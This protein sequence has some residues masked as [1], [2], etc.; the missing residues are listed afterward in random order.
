MTEGNAGFIIIYLNSLLSTLFIQ[1]SK[2]MNQE[3]SKDQDFYLYELIIKWFR[4]YEFHSILTTS[5][6]IPNFDFLTK[7]E[8]STIERLILRF[9][10]NNLNYSL[11]IQDKFLFQSLYDKKILRHVDEKLGLE[12]EA[13]ASNEAIFNNPLISQ[14]YLQHA[15]E[16]KEISNSN[17][18]FDFITTLESIN[19]ILFQNMKQNHQISQFCFNFYENLQNSLSYETFSS[20]IFHSFKE[21]QEEPQILLESYSSN[22]NLSFSV[23]LCFVSPSYDLNNNQNLQNFKKQIH[24]STFLPNSNTNLKILFFTIKKDQ[25]VDQIKLP[26]SC[27]F[28]FIR[29]DYSGID[30]LNENKETKEIIFSGHIP[31]SKS[32]NSNSSTISNTPYFSS[33]FSNGPFS[34]SNPSSPFKSPT[35]TQIIHETNVVKLFIGQ[36][37]RTME[38]D[39]LS[40]LFEPYGKIFEICIIRDKIS[41]NHC[42]CAF[43]TYYSPISAEKAIQNLHGVHTF[44]GQN[45]PMQVKLADS[46]EEKAGK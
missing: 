16:S 12:W 24:S 2:K 4:S 6:G 32:S 22:D 39:S 37:P 15:N 9:M 36:I 11:R 18:N 28:G 41:G 27:F 25:N 40:S 23:L 44:P 19:P 17:D 45:R 43:V 38:E 33:P 35:A 14:L 26:K 30:L 5:R 20:P 42:G 31:N 3:V 1:F 21:N 13:S 46:E 7:D 29:N 8:N 10:M 34:N